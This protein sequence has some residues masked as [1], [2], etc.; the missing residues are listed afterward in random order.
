MTKFAFLMATGLTLAASG[1]AWA[2][3]V[4]ASDPEAIAKLMQDWGYRAELTK[5][6]EG[7]PKINTSAAGVD[8]YVYFYGCS[9][10]ADCTEIQ[11]GAGFDLPD[12]MTLEAVNEW[13]SQ[14][15]FNR[16]YLDE[17]KDPFIR[18][19]VNLAEGGISPELFKEILA[20][21]ERRLADF[22]EH[23]NW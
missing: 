7:D 21:Y 2:E 15:R 8:F 19:D 16:V 20:N 6:S 12:G 9:G 23:I 18:Y 14:N 17:E 3:N 10:G 5:D 4:V 13:S 1:A 11:L 22:Q